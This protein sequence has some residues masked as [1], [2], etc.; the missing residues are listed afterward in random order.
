MANTDRPSYPIYTAHAGTL[1]IAGGTIPRS[2]SKCAFH[3]FERG[4]WPIDFFVI[5]ANANQQA[6]K[7]MG[8]FK[9]KVEDDS[10]RRNSGNGTTFTVAFV[11]LRFHV[12]TESATTHEQTEKDAT[13]WRTVLLSDTQQNGN[14]NLSPYARK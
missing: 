11:P 9:H 6:M 10:S 12:N 2:A 3:Y 7:A 5:G 13:V 8:S 1:R 4:I 14:Y